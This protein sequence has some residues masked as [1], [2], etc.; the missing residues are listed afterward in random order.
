MA[1]YPILVWGSDYVFLAKDRKA[2]ERTPRS[3]FERLR[4]EAH[5]GKTRLLDSNGMLFRVTD[6]IITSSRI[7]ILNWFPGFRT[8]AILSDGKKL[9]LEEFK[10]CVQDAIRVRQ[11]GEYDSDFMGE[12]LAKLPSAN[13]YKEALA[14]VPRGM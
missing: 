5:Q 3:Q 14:C 7:P 2:I 6:R 8:A 1:S 11:M 10:R 9:N 13:N 12:F 4:K